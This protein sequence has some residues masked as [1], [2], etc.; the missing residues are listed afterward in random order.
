M[1]IGVLIVAIAQATA[2]TVL[3]L[4]YQDGCLDAEA[5]VTEYQKISDELIL[6]DVSNSYL[7]DESFQKAI[8]EILKEHTL[9]TSTRRR[10]DLKAQMNRL[11]SQSAA[12]VLM[13]E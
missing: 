12:R 4:S 8:S 13:S 2:R 9:P 11:S 3:G 5:L 6:L 7:G 1:R 10:L